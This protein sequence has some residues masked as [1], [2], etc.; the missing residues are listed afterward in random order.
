MLTVETEV[1]G[2]SKSTNE[3]GPSLAGSLGLS[4]RN[5]RFL[6]RLGCSSWPS[7]FIFFLTV[8]PISIHLSPS[9]S[10]LG[11]QSCWVASIL[12]CVFV[13]NCLIVTY[14]TPFVLRKSACFTQ[15]KKGKKC[16]WSASTMNTA[17]CC[18][19]QYSTTDHTR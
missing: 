10:K 19:G 12:V 2:Y 13:S 11:R 1:N 4:C 3:R 15:L 6:Y 7:I 16:Y 8:Y 9:P 18:T 5:K 17:S 14:T